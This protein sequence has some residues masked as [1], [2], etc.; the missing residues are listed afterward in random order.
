MEIYTIFIFTFKVRKKFISRT[1]RKTQKP[2]CF[3]PVPNMA[4]TH[5]VTL[6]VIVIYLLNQSYT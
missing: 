3:F 6:P 5:A 1:S 2:N 4:E